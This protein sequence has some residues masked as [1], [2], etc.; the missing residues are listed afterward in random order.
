MRFL[1]VFFSFSI[2]II[3]F[4]FQAS[5][6]DDHSALN[7]IIAKTSKAYSDLPVERVYMHFDK[8]YYAVGDTIWFKAYLT[9]GLHV[10]SPFSKV[11]YVDIMAPPRLGGT[12]FYAAGKKWPGLGQYPFI[13]IQL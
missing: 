11:I 8:P 1:K 10:P 6:Q 5:A 9:V 3:S 4:S 13:A 7:T 12:I 2:F